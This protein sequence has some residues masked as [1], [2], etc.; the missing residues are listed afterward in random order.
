MEINGRVWG[1]LPLAV[2]SGVDFP[3]RWLEL[4]RSGPPPPGEPPQT[5]YTVGVRSRDFALEVAWV[6]A[7]LLGRRRH[8]FEPRP[9][10]SAAL[11]VAWR[12]LSRADG[13]D[14][15]SREDPLPGLLEFP[16]AVRVAVRQLKRR[17]RR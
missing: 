14:V 16:H 8:R 13:D 1:S 5:H 12:L 7:V 17:R 6:A 11:R 10:R 2:K 4:Y 15:L 9:P 3:A